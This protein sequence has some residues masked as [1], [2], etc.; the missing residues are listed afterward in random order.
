MGLISRLVCFA[1]ITSIT[2][3]VA[4]A[5]LIPASRRV[6]WTPGVSVGVPGGIPQDRTRLIDVT[7]APYNADKTGALD[8]SG[9]I[10]SAISAA[11][12]GDVVYL[13]AGTYLCARQIN[14]GYKSEITLRGEGAQTVL[15]STA[16]GSVF[17][18][19]GGA[20]DYNWSW[21][22]TGNNITAGLGKGSTTITIADTSQ[23]SPGQI[24]RIA[25]DNDPAIPVIS[26][27]GYGRLRRQMTRVTAKTANTLTISPA[28]YGDYSKASAVVNVAQMQANFVGIENMVIDMSR[29]TAAFGIWLEQAY[30]CW[31]KDVRIKKSAN[32]HMFLNDSLNCEVRRCFLDELNHVGPN[33]AGMMCASISGCL[34]EDNIVYKAFPLIEVNHGSSGNV[35]AYNFL[36]DSAPGVAIDSN[37][38]PHNSY[39]LYEGN[40]APNLQSDGYFGSASHDTVYRNWFH[41]ILNNEMS[42]CV[43][44]NRFTREYSL[45]GNI[46][47]KPGL[48]WGGGDGVYLGN[49]N[50]GNSYYSGSAPPWAMAA[51]T[52]AGT[53]TQSGNSVS[54][55]QAMF[56]PSNVGWFVLTNSPTSSSLSQITAYVDAQ[57]V[58]VNTSQAV[59]NV[60]YILSPGP[61]GYQ[62]LDGGVAATLIRKGNFYYA[63]SGIPASEELT[64]ALPDSMFRSSKPA[65]FENLAWPAFDPRNPS[66]SATSIPAGVRYTTGSNSPEVTPALPTDQKPFSVRIYP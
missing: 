4:C 14:L 23:F 59:S 20:S 9:A 3:S 12:K 38:G 5:E 50:M 37:H 39:N 25:V 58:K 30:G 48:N 64:E 33:G 61:S 13:P 29:S 11:T 66:P 16:D 55:S 47:Q 10:Q 40:V 35:F 34:I 28:L 60:S 31:V 57:N 42:W 6:D 49:P 24:V 62:E 54:S 53:V 51:R 27:Y 46:I 41:G 17:L 43:S 22:T 15:N 21:P 32:F 8:A 63:K 65:F 18:Q 44:L 19:V 56:S 45:V 7:K 1:T 36:E 52:G 26:V 2:A